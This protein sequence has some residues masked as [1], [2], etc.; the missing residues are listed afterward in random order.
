MKYEFIA[1]SGARFE[2]DIEANKLM[3]D[4]AKV[5][6]SLR[7]DKQPQVWMNKE[8]CPDFLSL[9]ANRWGARR[10]N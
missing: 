10:T 2:M 6:E 3:L 1:D 9:L 8:A 7:K 4:V 5:A